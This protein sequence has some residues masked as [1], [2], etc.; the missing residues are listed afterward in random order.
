MG[1]SKFG[2]W[3]VVNA[4]LG[5]G[6]SALIRDTSGATAEAWAGSSGQVAIARLLRRTLT[7]ILTL[8]TDPDPDH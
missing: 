1:A 3:R 2:H 6:A 5:A 7:L 4:L 8:T